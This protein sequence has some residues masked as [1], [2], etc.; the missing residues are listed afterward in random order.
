MTDETQ[1]LLAIKKKFSSMHKAEKKKIADDAVE[2]IIAEVVD[3]TERNKRY[4]NLLNGK[5]LN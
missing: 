2:K 1:K 4:A 5:T 3:R